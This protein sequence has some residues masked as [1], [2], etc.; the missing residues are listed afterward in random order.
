MCKNCKDEICTNRCVMVREQ[1]QKD[2]EEKK[3][4]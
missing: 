2:A 3:G 4:R 1:R